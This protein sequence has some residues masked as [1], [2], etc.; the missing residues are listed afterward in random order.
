[1]K[2]SKVMPVVMFFSLFV[3]FAGGCGSSE[4]VT[5]K[6]ADEYF[7]AAVVAFDDEDW[8][9]AIKYFEVIKL[10]Y[11]ASQYADDAQYFIAEI[12]FRRSEYYSAAYNYATLRRIY[13]QS[14]FQKEALFRTALSF[15]MLS[16]TFDRDQDYTKK[17]IQTFSEFQVLYPKDSLYGKASEYIME[18]RNKLAE[19]YYSIAQLYRNIQSIESSLVY[20]DAVI[21][22]YPDT[23][24]FEPSYFG[25]IETLSTMRKYE[26][27]RSII[28][29]YSQLFPKS[30]R[31]AQV[32]EIEKNLPY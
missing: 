27:L 24:F 6:T 2:I 32:K 21:E 23:D 1:M 26:Q 11:P 16:P 9:D 17:A 15:Y 4:T 12:N 14:E 29:L 8:L 3:I 28:I 20:Y 19:K 7:K 10:Q 5:I 18:L 31:L 30:T 22:E 13:P 25:K